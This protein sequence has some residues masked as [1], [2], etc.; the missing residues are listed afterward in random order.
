MLSKSV[1][2]I[3]DDMTMG[4][5]HDQLKI[6]GAKLLLD[7]VEGLERGTIKPIP[8]NNAEATYASLIKKLKK[9]VWSSTAKEIHNKVRGLN[10][11]PGAH[12]FLPDGRNLKIWQTRVAEEYFGVL[13]G[14]I[15]EFTKGG[16]LVACGKGCLE[17][18]EVQPESKKKMSAD[19][20]AMG[21]KLNWEI[22]PIEV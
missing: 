22:L 11:Q 3:S 18:L 5:L 2:E 4:C 1:I 21:I 7:V 9:I 10:P 14:T 19:V 15:I 17:V 16:F 20:F 12:S 8:Q 13:P 6:A